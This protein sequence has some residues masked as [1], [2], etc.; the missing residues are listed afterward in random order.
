[1][2]HDIA[3]STVLCILAFAYACSLLLIIAASSICLAIG[4]PRDKSGDAVAKYRWQVKMVKFNSD[5]NSSM[6]GQYRSIVP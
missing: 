6:A 2:T 4:F 5:E 1:M 3:L